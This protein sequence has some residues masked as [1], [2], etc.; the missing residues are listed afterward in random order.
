MD[1]M[2][3]WIAMHNS[4]LDHEG[5]PIPEFWKKEHMEI[6]DYIKSYKDFP[7][8]GIDFKDI[9]SLCNSKGFKLTCNDI[10]YKLAHHLDNPKVKILALDARGFIFGSVIADRNNINLV[11]CRKIGKLPGETIKKD[12]ELEYGKTTLEI[13]T[14]A[15][16]PNDNVIIIDDLIATGGTIMATIE[17]A[18]KLGANVMAVACPI[19]LFYLGGSTKIK[20]LGIDFYASVVYSN[21]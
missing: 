11:L 18:E 19:D 13:Q 15:I 16:Q 20:E 9:S 6:K 1:E 21:D 14:N 5:K 17:I 7:I 8:A 3:K 2:N 12:V 4:C 10:E